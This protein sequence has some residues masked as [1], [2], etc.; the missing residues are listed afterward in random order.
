[1]L[2]Y[3]PQQFEFSTIT[4]VTLWNVQF[5]DVFLYKFCKY[6]RFPLLPLGKVLCC[7]V[8][9]S[10]LNKRLTAAKLSLSEQ[11]NPTKPWGLTMLSL[12]YWQART[13]LQASN[14][15]VPGK[16]LDQVITGKRRR[17][18]RDMV[19]KEGKVRRNKRRDVNA[20]QSLESPIAKYELMTF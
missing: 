16:R 12:Q 9:H 3:I 7:E 14:F 18:E 20:Q 1:M 8:K 13:W 11:G 17:S 2:R 19:L 4:E 5:T 6:N 10:L 15:M